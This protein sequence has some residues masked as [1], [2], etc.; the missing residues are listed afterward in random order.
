[1][2]V[3]GIDTDNKGGRA[4]EAGGSSGVFSKEGAT[5]LDTEARDSAGGAAVAARDNGRAVYC[6]REEGPEGAQ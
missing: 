2:L 3:H 6:E 5:R 1:V 4:V